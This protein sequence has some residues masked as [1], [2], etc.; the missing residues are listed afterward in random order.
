MLCNILTAAIISIVVAVILIISGFLINKIFGLDIGGLFNLS[1]KYLIV[2]I[3][4]FAVIIFLY[5]LIF[6]LT[7][8]SSIF[9]VFL[10]ASILTTYPV[11]IQPYRL[12]RSGTYRNSELEEWLQMKTGIK[13]AILVSPKKFTNALVFGVLPVSRAIII[14][15]DLQENM[16]QSQL[17]AIVLHEAGHLK[18]KHTAILAVVNIVTAFAL[19]LVLIFLLRNHVMDYSPLLYFTI[20]DICGLSLYFIPAPLYRRLELKADSFAGRY[21]GGGSYA[22]MLLRLD[23][24]TNS[25]VSNND[26]YHPSLKKR[27]INVKK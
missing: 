5:Q 6:I 25:G 26:F 10:M 17:H 9:F 21:V 19:S 11:L 14:S 2:D 15:K 16:T 18:L 24:I 8:R 13:A 7:G 27:I 22:E 20:L 12:L 23:E 1:G 4:V 3:T